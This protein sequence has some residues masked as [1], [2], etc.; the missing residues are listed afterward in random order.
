VIL[1]IAGD[2][3]ILETEVREMNV[4]NLKVEVEITDLHLINVK[5]DMTTTEE[6]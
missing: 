6:M 3:G 5:I 1:V 4:H 2:L